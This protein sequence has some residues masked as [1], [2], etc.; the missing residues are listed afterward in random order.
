MYS[1]LQN[2]IDK[3]I[4]LTNKILYQICNNTGEYSWGNGKFLGEKIWLIGRSYAASPERRYIKAKSFDRKLELDNVGDG[5]GKYFDEIGEYIVNNEQY[6]DL[7]LA[8]N[9]LQYKY[10][11]DGSSNDLDL[12]KRSVEAV[13]LLN[14][15]V[16]CASKRY[17]DENNPKIKGNVEYR[18]QISFCSKFLHFHCPDIVFIIDGFT[19][20]AASNL[21]SQNSKKQL[22]IENRKIA[23]SLKNVLNFNLPNQP[24]KCFDNISEYMKFCEKSYALCRYIKNSQLDISNIT[25]YPRTSDCILQSIKCS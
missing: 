12:L 4:S 24:I 6:K 18:N 11:F 1:E 8:L 9:E 22:Y 5:T 17:D 10:K 19:R 7:V 13:G 2:L 21:F 3:P 25:Y 20:R 16:K 15:M 14:E 23:E